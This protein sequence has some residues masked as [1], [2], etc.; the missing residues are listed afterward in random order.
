MEG[1]VTEPQYI[2]VFRQWFGHRN[3]RLQMVR[4]AGDPCSVVER[5]IEEL[6]K[7]TNDALAG[8]DTVWVM[9]DR[10]THPGFQEARNRASSVGI[11]FAVS[12][13]CF[14]L[15]GILHFQDQNAHLDQRECQRVLEELCSQYNRRS[16][17]VF[18][19]EELVRTGSAIAATRARRL[20]DLHNRNGTPG[21]CPSTTVHE[22]LECYLRMDP[23]RPRPDD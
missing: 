8:Q 12:N 4:G 23:A 22:L 10:D 18:A 3:A 16:N 19:S 7:L 5:A 11:R 20:L 6:D 2:D 17:K 13:P 15:W 21:G 1:T 9:F 14:E